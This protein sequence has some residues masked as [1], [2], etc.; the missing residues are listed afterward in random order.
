MADY[1]IR[2]KDTYNVIAALHS[3]D[4][5][6]YC[7]LDA[8]W[9]MI[10]GDLRPIRETYP[11]YC[12]PGNH[13]LG[14]GTGKKEV[15]GYMQYRMYD[16]CDVRDPERQFNG[17]ECWYTLLEEQGI[18]LVGIG[19]HMEQDDE[20]PRNDWLNAVLDAY[21]AYPA[22][23][24][25]HSFLDNDPYSGVWPT[26]AGSRLERSVL[27]RHPNVRLL[28][29]GHRSGAVRWEQIY[30]DGRVFTAIM[31][32][33]QENRTDGVGACTL[34]TFYPAGRSITVTSYSPY[35]DIYYPYDG[36]EQ[37]SFTLENAY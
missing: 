27:S 16:L 19:F 11:F 34:L 21:S 7:D 10:L 31:F 37:T 13:D 35:L 6:E 25:T 23:I 22:V 12:V 26:T 33:M 36:S 1:A 15:Y 17:G 9:E 20:K 32:N 18:L 4:F 28:L 24:L 5:V 29:C 8:E 30:E 3:G 2:I 14:R